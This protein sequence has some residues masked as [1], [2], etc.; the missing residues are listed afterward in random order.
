MFFAGLYV[1]VCRVFV[2]L[3]I[4]RGSVCCVTVR[5]RAG[6]LCCCCDIHQCL[7]QG[8]TLWCAVCLCY[9]LLHA[10]EFVVLL[11]VTHRAGLLCCCCDICQCL[12]QG[13]TLLYAVCLCYSLLHVVAFVVLP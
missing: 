10:V 13:C 2:L 7:L 6:L 4:T 3:A 9:L 11:S 5:H 1:V 12:L 8:C